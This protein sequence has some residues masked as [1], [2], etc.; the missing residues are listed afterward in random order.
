MN[1]NSFSDLDFE[2]IINSIPSP[3]I[4]PIT[5]ADNSILYN[6]IPMIK[7]KWSTGKVRYFCNNCFGFNNNF[8]KGYVSKYECY[9]SL[10]LFLK[11]ENYKLY[12]KQYPKNQLCQPLTESITNEISHAEK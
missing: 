7:R 11:A 4:K 9:R 2:R 6:D 3:S 8:N 5:Y 1:D 12:L 10:V